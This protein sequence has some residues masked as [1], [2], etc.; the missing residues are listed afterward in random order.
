M[1][2]MIYNEFNDAVLSWEMRNK[3]TIPSESTL[4]RCLVNAL[5]RDRV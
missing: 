1:F 5:K 2:F 4:F 3:E